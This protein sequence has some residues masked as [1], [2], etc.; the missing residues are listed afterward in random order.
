M[1]ASAATTSPSARRL[2]FRLMRCAAAPPRARTRRPAL[3]AGCTGVI[4]R[5]SGLRMRELRA[6][7]GCAADTEC[8]R[9]ALVHACASSDET[10]AR[11][12]GRVN[13]ECA[14]MRV[15]AMP[16]PARAAS[17]ERACAGPVSARARTSAHVRDSGGG[18]RAC[19]AAQSVGPGASVIVSLYCGVRVS[20]GMGGGEKSRERGTH[21]LEELALHRVGVTVV[22]EHRRPAPPRGESS[23]AS[24]PTS[25]RERRQTHAPAV[26]RPA[27]PAAHRVRELR[28]CLLLLHPLL[29][30]AQ[31]PSR[32]PRRT[33][34]S[35]SRPTARR[36]SSADASAV[37]PASTSAFSART[38]APP[39]SRT[40]HA[41]AITSCAARR[42]TMPQL[43]IRAAVRRCEAA[44]GVRE[45]VCGWRG[46]AGC[47]VTADL[48]V[49][50]LVDAASGG[51]L[52]VRMSY[53]EGMTMRFSDFASEMC[54]AGS[55]GEWEGART[56]VL[57]RTF[58]ASADGCG[59][60]RVHTR[61]SGHRRRVPASVVAVLG[62]SAVPVEDANAYGEVDEVEA[63]SGKKKS[64]SFL[65]QAKQR[66]HIDVGRGHGRTP[67]VEGSGRLEE[68]RAHQWQCHPGRGK[69]GVSSFSSDLLP[70]LTGRVAGN[71]TKKECGVDSAGGLRY[72]L[73]SICST[74]SRRLAAEVGIYQGREE[75]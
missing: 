64:A 46:R 8:A 56:G 31:Q 29:Y 50:V 10:C 53:P 15:A 38:A 75:S 72:M 67:H 24:L 4:Q 7:R 30:L 52:L 60:L 69:P 17:R 6:S 49:P 43:W 26:H 32:S 25:E 59:R 40:L 2:G 68:A 47:G 66:R 51:A 63:G 5:R 12:R 33:R 42:C 70:L 71:S 54:Y 37:F 55:E 35:R 34:I 44:E 36:I 16:A 14:F 9:A 28:A 22:L 62:L 23:P 21:D 1:R 19:V 57:C 27:L 13:T 45:T 61:P 48:R 18:S 41:R 11:P 74:S 73:S 65:L 39:S 20:E 3:P 58:G